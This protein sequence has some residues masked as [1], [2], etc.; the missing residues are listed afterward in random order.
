MPRLTFTFRPDGRVE[1]RVSNVKGPGCHA[2]T[3]EAEAL[4][5]RTVT[6]TRTPEYYQA[7]AQTPQRLRQESST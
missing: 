3:A 5:G 6:Q 4:L 2:L 1:I 7:Q